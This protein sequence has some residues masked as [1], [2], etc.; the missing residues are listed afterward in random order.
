M[1]LTRMKNMFSEIKNRKLHTTIIIILSI[2]VSFFIYKSQQN[3]ITAFKFG[4]FSLI[5]S[6]IAY[7]DYKKKIIPNTMIIFLF[8]LV[9]VLN[10]WKWDIGYTLSTTISFF[11]I[12]VISF[13]LHIISKNSIGMGDVKLLTVTAA[14]FGINYTISLLFVTFVLCSI[15]GIILLAVFK[16]ERKQTI[17]FAPVLLLGFLISVMFN[18]I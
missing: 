3:I 10:L 11:V 6:P 15:L 5:L 13:V 8:I 18:L 1:V 16:K 4:T 9:L 12:G 14:L 7:I 17:A 2:T